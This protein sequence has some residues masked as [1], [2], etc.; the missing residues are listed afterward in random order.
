MARSCCHLNPGI[1]LGSAN[2]ETIG[3]CV[4]PD[5]MQYE[6]HRIA[7]KVFLPKQNLYTKVQFTENTENQ[8]TS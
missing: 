1:K 8:R 7:Y 4:P 6:V 3:Y 2:S 5:V